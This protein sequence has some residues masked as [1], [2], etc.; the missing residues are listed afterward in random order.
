MAKGTPEDAP[1]CPIGGFDLTGGR[2]GGELGPAFP[3]QFTHAI[4]CALPAG[5]QVAEMRDELFDFIS[6]WDGSED[7]VLGFPSGICFLS[8]PT[9]GV[10][11][12][13]PAY[14]REAREGKASMFQSLMLS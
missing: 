4:E 7:S 13:R 9:P 14:K 5:L 2:A 3:L 6:A 11:L 1:S 10:L 12:A 8:S